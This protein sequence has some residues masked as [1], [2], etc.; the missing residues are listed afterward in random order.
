MHE[1][2]HELTEVVAKRI[3]MDDLHDKALKGMGTF[4]HCTVVED[5]HTYAVRIDD[6]ALLDAV[7]Q[8]ELAR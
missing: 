8:I 7:E 2:A 5:E 6:D 3:T 4:V 1:I